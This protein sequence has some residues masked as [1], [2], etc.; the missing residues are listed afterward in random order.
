MFDPRSMGMAILLTALTAFG[1]LSTDMYLPSLPAMTRDFGAAVGD[2]QLTLSLFLVGF[3]AGQIVYG[4]LSDRFG[5]RPALILGVG[6]YFA[7]SII[8]VLSGAVEVLIGARFLQGLGAA[9]GPVL[10]RAVVRDIHSTEKAARMLS[11]MGSAMA[12]APLVAPLLGGYLAVWWGW[13]AIFVALALFGGTLLAALVLR[14][15][16]TNAH[17]D[18]QA[19]RPRH[20]LGNYIALLGHRVYL[21]YVLCITCCYAG[22][23]SF[24]SGSSFVF[25]DFLGVPAQWFGFCFGAVV[26][27]YILGAFGAGRWVPRV[28]IRRM[29][30][31]GVVLNLGAGAAQLSLA[32][33]GVATVAAVLAPMVVY[34]VGV[35]LVI[36]NAMAGAIGP[37]PHMA[38]TASA[39]LGFLQ[40]TLA[41][42]VGLAVGQW[43]DGTQMPMVTATAAMGLG[44][45]GFY[46]LMVLRRGT[47]A[48]TPPP[49]P[50]GR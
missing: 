21:G 16:E 42:L 23:F 14:L 10:A 49:P 3:A 35:G 7:A 5:R 39:L 29:I 4:P 17:K 31:L 34:M 6:L 36:P 40:M 48:A 2:V 33:A 41:S 19:T 28:G 43:D 24:I 25:I 8:C 46:V 32:L 13:Q 22:L 18:P 11:Y 30:L 27:G 37:F 20:L 1:P 47:A 15:P 50:P 45:F 38:G 44:T 26:V 9:A 12:L